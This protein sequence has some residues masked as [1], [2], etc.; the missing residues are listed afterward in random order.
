MPP[1]VEHCEHC[2]AF[3]AI[4]RKQNHCCTIR[5]LAII[6]KAHRAT[7][8]KRIEAQYGRAYAEGLRDQV[9]A[10]Y[11]RHKAHRL[12]CARS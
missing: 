2:L 10:E 4:Y 9:N 1:P 11:A 6:P 5:M 8:Y 3:S 12:S 7:E